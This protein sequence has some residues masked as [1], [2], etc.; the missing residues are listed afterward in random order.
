[1]IV[2]QLIIMTY[3]TVPIS[4]NTKEL[5]LEQARAAIAGG[6]E[7]LEL[8]TDYLDNLQPQLVEQLIEDV[9]QI[10]KMPLLITCR[11]KNEGGANNYPVELRIKILCQAVKAGVEFIDFEYENFR[12]AENQEKI[13][14]ALAET[15]KTRLILSAHNF[16]SPFEDLAA[17]YRH[18]QTVF[19]T[20]IPKLVYKANHINDC[21]EAF[22]LL[23][24]T[25]GERIILAMGESGLITRILAKKFNCLVTFASLDNSTQTAPGQISIAE[26]KNLYKYADI[27]SETQV[28]GIIGSPVA[29]SLS[30]VLHNGCYAEKN[31]NKLYLPLLVDGSKKD[32]DAFIHNVLSRKWLGFKGFS[33]TIPHKLNALELA[34]T[35]DGFIEP[36]A[37]KIGAANTLTISKQNTLNAYNTDYAGAMDAISES[38]G[39]ERADLKNIPTAVI[40]A[41]GVAR[42]I[43]AGLTDAGA[44]V[45]IYN[46]TISK[47]R[48]LA[49]E[50]DTE[51]AG[52]DELK[53]LDAKLLINCTSIGMSPDIDKTPIEAKYLKKDMAV[54][55]TIYNPLETL[56]L[57]EAKQTGAKTI[58]GMDMFINQAAQQFYLFTGTKIECEKLRNI[59]TGFTLKT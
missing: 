53:T 43:V 3:L 13:E 34:K 49:E 25:S 55:D 15:A 52:L 35:Q 54:F 12:H 47:A 44:K 6:A 11:D 2:I 8:R 31:M 37:A 27:N 9:R 4:A 14:L 21:F 40:G 51:F 36:L 39:I 1:M 59:L 18:I 41:G 50:F 10:A 33:V 57:K 24:R 7:M 48:K 29:H 46:R 16:K 26:L 20:A 42:A 17:L 19:P 30:P 38:L 58:N 23:S 28:F 22:D 5:M 45:K 56:L 32:F